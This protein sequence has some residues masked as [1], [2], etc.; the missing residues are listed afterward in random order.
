MS[1]P[2]PIPNLGP[3]PAAVSDLPVRETDANP[4]PKAR[5]KA[6]NQLPWIEQLNLFEEHLA[7]KDSGNQPA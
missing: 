2:D 7:A 6:A 4:T 3:H 1:A 5:A